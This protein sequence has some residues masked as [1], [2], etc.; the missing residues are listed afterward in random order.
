MD[1]HMNSLP[2]QLVNLLSSSAI[3]VFVC[4]YFFRFNKIEK[5]F[6]K[7]EKK[8]D[9]EYHRVIDDALEHERK[10]L[11]DTTDEAEHIINEAKYISSSSKEAL[12]QALQ[13]AVN[14]ILKESLTMGHTYLDSYKSSLNE[15]SEESRKNLQQVTKGFE[16]D[17]KRQTEDFRN[18]AR[19]LEGNLQKQISEFHDS[20][21]PNLE[22]ELE[23]YKAERLKQTDQ[24]VKSI[25][26]KASVEI[27]NKSISLEDHQKLVMDSLEKAKKEGAFN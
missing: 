18:V 27:I 6:E 24:L 8:V 9:T 17:L 11:S 13:K 21:M 20:L 12:E 2:V 4:Y 16:E 7:K 10:I 15:I 26:Q 25:V 1:I 3:L 14:D 22:K 5:E 19:E 23:A